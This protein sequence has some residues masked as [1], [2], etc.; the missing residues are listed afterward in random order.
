MN[1]E[2]GH[3]DTDPGQ[4]DLGSLIPRHGVQQFLSESVILVSGQFRPAPGHLDCET[5]GSK[6]LDLV[7]LVCLDQ[8]P[9]KVPGLMRQ[10]GQC[11]PLVGLLEAFL[12]AG[13]RTMVKLED[14]SLNI[15]TCQLNTFHF[16]TNILYTS[17]INRNISFTIT[18]YGLIFNI[19]T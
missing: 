9:A 14:G 2:P 19:L 3:G 1:D 10:L 11:E 12:T 7:L 18:I 13:G 5:G 8:V 16:V 17:V 15:F 6:E 4:D